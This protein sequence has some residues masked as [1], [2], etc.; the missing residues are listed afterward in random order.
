[1]A[2]TRVQTAPKI[3]TDTPSTPPT[4]L[5]LGSGDGWVAPTAGNLLVV[6]Y[7]GVQV[8]S[9]GPTG[10]TAGPSVVDDNAGYLWW[11]I[12]AGTET[13]F[14]VTQ[15]GTTAATLVALEVSGL[16]AAPFDIQ[17]SSNTTG[18][19]GT[20]T[21]AASI[22]TTGANG[23]DWVLAVGAL[24]ADAAG[25]TAPTGLAWSNGYSG[26]LSQFNITNV[27]GVNQHLTALAELQQSAAGA[28]ST[29]LTW[30]NG[31]NARQHMIIGFKLAATAAPAAPPPG[32]LFIG[33][34]RG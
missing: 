13:T 33:P 8:V 16:L 32:V 34:T 21:A 15:A 20:T 24:A 4:T 6:V 25:T 27:N 30:T 26:F 31:W 3:W 14:S 11:K 5:T 2:A 29:V 7:N 1:M 18:T 17:N 28:T 9:T 23:G 22:T 12:A 19:V 10:F